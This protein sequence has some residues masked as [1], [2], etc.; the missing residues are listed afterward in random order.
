MQTP[1]LFNAPC[2]RTLTVAAPE[3]DP[4]WTCGIAVAGNFSCPDGAGLACICL[5][6]GRHATQNGTLAFTTACM[7]GRRLGGRS[8]GD[9]MLPPTEDQPDWHSSQRM[10]ITTPDELLC[11]RIS[12]Y[13]SWGSNL[14]QISVANIKQKAAMCFKVMSACMVPCAAACAGGTLLAELAASAGVLPLPASATFL[15]LPIPAAVASRITQAPAQLP[16]HLCSCAG[17]LAALLL[18]AQDIACSHLSRAAGRPYRGI[19]PGC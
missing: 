6:D 8:P 7:G 4:L 13:P 9:E 10:P 2:T 18:F 1:F 19:S 16:A 5:R 15:P 17:C 3:V 11:G 14:F 12:T